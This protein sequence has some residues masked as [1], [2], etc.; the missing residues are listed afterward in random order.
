MKTIGAE[1]IKTI[2]LRLGE[3]TRQG[4]KDAAAGHS[5]PAR[6]FDS[7]DESDAYLIGMNR[8]HKIIRGDQP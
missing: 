2:M 4:E 3:A 5:T 7:K 6:M 1:D 8:Q